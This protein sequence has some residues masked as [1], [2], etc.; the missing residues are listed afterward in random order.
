MKAGGSK[1]LSLS[2]S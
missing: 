1:E 2:K